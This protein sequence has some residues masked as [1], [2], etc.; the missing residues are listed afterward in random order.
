MRG[1][2]IGIV[3][4]RRLWRAAALA[5]GVCLASVFVPPANAQSA[6]AGAGAAGAGSAT[7]G[8]AGTAT[9]SG[10]ATS[11]EAA[12]PQGATTN[13][14]AL[15]GQT[16]QA[17][18]SYAA[19]AA[20]GMDPRKP[21]AAKP[22]ALTLQEV[23]DRAKAGNPTLL[24]AE[25]NLR[26]VRALEIQAAVRQ[27]PYF[28]VAGSEITEP[29]SSPNPYTYSVQI[30]RLF[31]RGNKREYRIDNAKA[32]STQTEAQLNETI[33]Q[34]VLQVKDAFTHM[35]FAKQARDLSRAQLADFQHEVDIAHDR[36]TA[37][38]LG[39]LDFERLDLQL[40]S[41]ESDAANDEIA[42]VQASDQL[43]TMMGVAT[44]SPDFDVSGDIVPPAVTETR[45]E[46]IQHALAAR[47]D[48]AAAHA[49][50]NV[51][52]SAYRLAVANG[53]ADPTLEGEYD[54]AGTEN[55]AGFSV[56][57]PLRIFDRNQGNKES[58]R[59]AIDSAQFTETAAHNQVSSDVDQAWVAYVQAR[60]LSDRFGNHYLD[61]S[62]DVLGIARFAFDHGG[63]ALIDYLDA[64]RD[65]RSSTSDA[66]NAYLQT[67]LAIHQLSASSAQ[68]VVP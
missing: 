30:S 9:A 40:G 53:T 35:L 20:P 29:A 58:S 65:A 33:R 54:R 17:P 46:L 64:L 59:L 49:G 22:G 68:E 42:V 27:N 32:T 41:F 8:T 57:I 34:T 38:D 14:A 25:A 28:G 23:I 15:S 4:H 24:A 26:S 7:A 1:L 18:A 12:G 16:A 31:E 19:S 37:G 11:G 2:A 50:V 36:Y 63:L 44:P 55:S 5:A 56:N 6:G 21:P 48:L 3:E 45:E 43:Q 13:A 39:K 47:P 60:R 66:L 61:E 62:A 51:A 52:Q 67:W 10:Q